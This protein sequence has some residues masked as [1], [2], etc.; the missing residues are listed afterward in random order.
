MIE[1]VSNKNIISKML[2][3]RITVRILTIISCIF[4]FSYLMSGYFRFAVLGLFSYITLIS[5]ELNN[6]I[7]ALRIENRQK[8]NL[9]NFIKKEEEA[10]QDE[11]N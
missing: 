11:A 2:M 3:G 1:L 4:L 9:N 5:I 10:H 6:Q 8:Y 7:N